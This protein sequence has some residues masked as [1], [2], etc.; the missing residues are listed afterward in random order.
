VNVA[1]DGA[2]L[3]VLL[4]NLIDNAVRHGGPPGPV[5]VRC[6]EDGNVARLEVADLGPGVDET[7]LTQLGHRFYR[8]SSARGPGSGLGLSIVQRIA[9]GCGGTVRYRH[10]AAGRGFVVEVLFPSR[11]A[12]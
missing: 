10:G 7:E 2:L 3:E 8:A 9:E 6:I 5:T 12:A 1:A 11:A 4:R